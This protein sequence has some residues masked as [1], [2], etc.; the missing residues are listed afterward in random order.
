MPGPT[1]CL[2]LLGAALSLAAA[3]PCA[4]H[5]ATDEAEPAADAAA[6]TAA[7]EARA[8]TA[9]KTLGGQLVQELKAAIEAEGPVHAIDVCHTIAPRIAD[10]TSARQN[11]SV[12]RTSHK[13]R[14]PTNLPDEWETEVLD[15]FLA[16]AE[17]GTPIAT[18][19]KGAV[20]DGEDGRH[21]RYM[22]GIPTKPL[23][24]NCHGA[25][26]TPEVQAAIDETYPQDRA[27]GFA[28]GD[29]RGAFTVSIPLDAED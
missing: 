27:T 20:V 12:G 9:I 14:N 23:C 22:K 6:D 18:L 5:A 2:R 7:L 8:R 13:V 4:A 24:L 28:V 16:A 19:E 21:F 10:E 11:L 3:L 25:D 29:L 15:A 26:L 1:P 17:A